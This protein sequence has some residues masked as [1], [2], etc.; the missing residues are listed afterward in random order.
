MLRDELNKMSIITTSFL[1]EKRN[2][3]GYDDAKFV[4]PIH[5][6]FQNFIDRPSPSA[7]LVNDKKIG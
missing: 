3:R 1:E 7:N 5:I 4:S 2:N 6:S